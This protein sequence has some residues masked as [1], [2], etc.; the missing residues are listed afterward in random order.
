MYTHNSRSM[1]SWD[2]LQTDGYLCL[3]FIINNSW[4]LKLWKHLTSIIHDYRH[5][6][7]C[8]VWI[9]LAITVFV[10]RILESHLPHVIEYS[11]CDVLHLYNGIHDHPQ[12]IITQNNCN[13]ELSRIEIIW[14][15]QNWPE[16]SVKN[17]YPC[18]NWNWINCWLL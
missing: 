3:M 14:A 1:T 5:N 15:K 2:G 7:P 6:S 17:S 13:L 11:S 4:L 18:T 9:Q 16:I 10:F 8:I 12:H